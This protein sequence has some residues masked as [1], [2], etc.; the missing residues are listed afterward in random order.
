M[1]LISR[2]EVT[3]YLTEGINP[4]RRSADWKPMLTGITLRTDGGKSALVNITNGGGKT[5]LVELLLYL[6]SRDARLLKKI[7]EKVAPKNRG[8]THARIEFRT[9]PEDNYSAPSLLEIDPLNLPGETHVVGVA[10]NDDI[11]EQPIFYSYSGTLEDS[12]CYL[13][14]RK[15]IAQMPDNA[16]VAATRALRGC[17]WNRFANRLEWEDHIRLFLPVEVIRRNVVYQLKG[18]DDQNAS[19]FDFKPRGGESHDSAFFRAVVAP[20][21]LSNLLS[22]F[23]EEDESAVED[24]LLKSL[25]QIVRADKEI[26]AKNKR[27]SVREEGIAKL[28]PILHAGR[29]ARQ[30]QQECDGLLRKLRGDV[31]FL[32]YFGIQGSRYALPGLPRSLPKLG[33]QD[34]RLL[35][36]LKGMVILPDEGIVLLDKTL[37][38]LSGVEVRVIS[39]A[40]ER[41]QIMSI[42]AKSQVID[43]ACD[44]GFSTSGVAGG[45][46][47][48]KGFSREAAIKLPELLGNNSG[49]KTM[50]LKEVLLQAFTI[51]EAQIDTNPGS[52]Q[53]RALETKKHSLLESAQSWEASQAQLTSDVNKLRLQIKDRAENQGAWDDFVGLGI[54]LPE[55]LRTEPMLAKTW[56]SEQFDDLQAEAA[57][58]NIRRGELNQV[59]REYTEVLDHHGL[60]G[61]QGAQDRLGSLQTLHDTIQAESRRILPAIREASK[62]ATALQRA[63]QPLADKRGEAS[64]LVDTFNR[65]APGVLRF[66]TVFGSVDPTEVDPAGA[67]SKAVK[68]HAVAQS[69][70]RGL[71]EERDN[72]WRLK[73]HSATF[74]EIF[75]AGTDSLT[76][77]PITRHTQTLEELSSVRQDLAT[78]LPQKEAIETFNDRFP[79]T[80]PYSWLKEAGSTRSRLR[81]ELQAHRGLETSLSKEGEAIEQMRSVEDGSF[82]VAW[83]ILADSP[84]R[85]VRLHQAL[86]SAE[87][88]P[89]ERL[90]AMSALSGMLSAPVF[91][92]TEDLNA[93][94][95]L[96]EGAAAWV[97]LI[98]KD[99]LASALS[100]GVASNGQVRMLGFIGGVTSRRVRILL[101][102][103]FARAELDRVA[104]ELLA[105]QS[106]IARIELGLTEVAPEGDAYQLALKAKAALDA[107]AGERCEGRGKDA[108]LLEKLLG[109]LKVQI[110]PQ[111]RAVLD[112]AKEFKKLNGLA[113][114]SDLDSLI[115]QRE[116]EVQKTSEAKAA[117]E[118]RASHENL[119]ARDDALE[120]CKLGGEAAFAATRT[121]YENACEAVEIAET[122]AEEA[123]EVLAELDEQQ[124]ELNRKQQAYAEDGGEQVRSLY[125]R[126]L[127]FAVCAEDLQFMRGFETAS[128]EISDTLAKIAAALAVKFERAEAF[129][130]HQGKSDMALLDEIASK[131]QDA[132]QLKAKAEDARARAERIAR[133]EVPSWQCLAKAIHEMAFEVGS[134]VAR[135]KA[136]ATQAANLEEGA[137]VPEAHAGYKQA[138]AV[139]EV[140]SDPAMES[141]G[142]VIESVEALAQA[143][144]AMD[145]H[146]ALQQHKAVANELATATEQYRDQNIRFCRAALE[147]VQSRDSAFNALEI[148]EIGRATPD[149]IEA[150]GVFFTQLQAS[151]SKERDEAKQAM[152]I[153]TQ[154]AEDTL[155]QLAGLIQSATDNLATLNKVMAR[156]PQGRF[157]FET[158]ITGKAGVQ[159]I[160]DELKLDVE[161]AL[162][163]QDGQSRG[164]RRGSDTQL[165][166]MLRERLIECVFTNTEVQ[167]VNGGIWGGRKSHVSGKL[168]TGQKI[169]LEFMW[170]VRQAEYEIERGLQEMTSKQ[171][172]KSRAK[173]NRVILIDGIFSTLSDRRIIK[174]ALNGL[175][176]LGGNFQII[177]FLH[178]PNWNNDFAVFPVYHVGKKLVNQEGDGLV[179]FRELGRE[180]GTVGF[181]ST[182]TQPLPP[183][184]AP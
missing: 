182:I 117:A 76:Y 54:L 123:Q 150:L 153:A 65:L 57:Q 26:A 33:E 20:D 58:R 81:E 112:A 141:Y 104:R 180:P 14:D 73:A 55:D 174:E 72:L 159:D 134:R 108:E 125:Q 128:K 167:F 46:H 176:D 42:P 154:T 49:A 148:E 30:L 61:L 31:A 92:S 84:I 38:E 126:V 132:D 106:A 140:L 100:R 157:F 124:Q 56:L 7:R 144:Q 63:I 64:R 146:E 119:T 147:A 101:E 41:K 28:E 109:Q 105:C 45:G 44:F 29:K 16:F 121:A 27:L 96:L 171:A 60:E 110:A 59:W 75:G 37:S 11:N 67:L 94:A 47:Y 98:L 115:P 158:Q 80:T 17:K 138:M 51:A 162:R 79:Q 83:A 163:D 40:A 139:F 36:A 97:P 168:S 183:E 9:P 18:S 164:M 102:P 179:S 6:L 8:Y 25:T 173:A 181:V 127:R 15:S 103:E 89:S 151:L 175:R 13:Y 5:S 87:M 35:V 88:P 43:F 70:L 82:E 152:T 86:L 62:V 34:P 114:L 165:K 118:E 1:S 2:V 32:R 3:N 107:R 137:A 68:A 178:S 130:A 12:P 71:A 85:V 172:A 50:G 145:L 53:V 93:A 111:A 131:E 21:L 69:T 155:T 122:K 78:L 161:R 22:S 170:I 95:Q 143:V 52:R 66:V 48:R 142:A 135:S 39:Q 160:L 91:E 129:R 133:A 23:A 120:H 156:Y 136:A 10:L 149:T 99:E 74:E 4:N 77:D 113:R 19:F 24:T 177:G 166:T 169:A 116:E 90:D 184:G